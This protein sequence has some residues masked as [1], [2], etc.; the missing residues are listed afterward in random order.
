MKPSAGQI[1]EMPYS[2]KEVSMLIFL[3]AEIEDDTTGLEKVEHLHT[4]D[5]PGDSFLSQLNEEN[6]SDWSNRLKLTNTQIL[7]QIWK[8]LDIMDDG[9]RSRIH[10]NHLNKSL[11]LK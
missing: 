7:S 5:V 2:G 9:C 1:L 6:K 10:D 4:R 3:P 8:L 11:H